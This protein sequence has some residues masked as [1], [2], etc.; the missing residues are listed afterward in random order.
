[1]LCLYLYEG[2]VQINVH[3]QTLLIITGYVLGLVHNG[4]VIWG[5][6]STILVSNTQYLIMAHSLQNASHMTYFCCNFKNIPPQH[7]A[8]YQ[9]AFILIG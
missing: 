7:S 5:Y 1:M 2:S 9:V 8:V 3:I 4:R 6:V